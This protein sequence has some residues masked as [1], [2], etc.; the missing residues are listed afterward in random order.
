MLHRNIHLSVNPPGPHYVTVK[1]D[2]LYY[3]YGCDDVQDQGWGCGYRTLQTLCSWVKFQQKA[4]RD[5]PT[6][7]EIQKALVEMGDKPKNFDGSR[8]WIGSFEVSI[9]IDFF[10]NVPCKIVHI[11]S[12]IELEDHLVALESHFN[13][14]GSPIMMGGDTDNSSKCILGVCFK[15]KSLLI[16]DPHCYDKNPTVDH[17]IGGGLIKWRMM[18]TFLESSFY[19]LCLPQ[20]KCKN[21]Q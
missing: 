17:V 15:P 3:H 12:G 8:E 5:V 21:K 6:I 14:F 11:R 1:E 10:F 2:Y 16:L 9:C 18:D 4:T 7:S 20:L 13:T 19:N